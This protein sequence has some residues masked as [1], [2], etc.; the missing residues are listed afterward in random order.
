MAYRDMNIAVFASPFVGGGVRLWYCPRS[1]R[2]ELRYTVQF[3][4][5]CGG[6]CGASA[7]CAYDAGDGSQ[8]VDLILDAVD[9]ANTPLL[10][11]D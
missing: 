5:P 7:L 11:R 6:V 3:R 9:I 2:Y 4:T 1:Q 8:V 10:D